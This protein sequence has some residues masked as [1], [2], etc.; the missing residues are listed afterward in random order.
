MGYRRRSKASSVIRDVAH[1]GSKVSW[2]GAL[3]LGGI[4]FIIF[5]FLL[6]SWVA[7]IL[8]EQQNNMFYPM[9]E[10]IFARRLHWL[11]WTGIATGLIGLYFS[12]RNYHYGSTAQRQERSLAGFIAKMLGKSID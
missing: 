1:I 7:S 3:W 9:L 12:F 10:A 5:Y 4:S 11:Q 2:M 6:P 8:E